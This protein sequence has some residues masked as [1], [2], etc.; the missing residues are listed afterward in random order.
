MTSLA[1]RAGQ[2]RKPVHRSTGDWPRP[3]RQAREENPA[4]PWEPQW[5]AV[6]DRAAA[7]GRG[8]LVSELPSMG[9]AIAGYGGSPAAERALEALFDVGRWWP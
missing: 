8:A 7:R 9:A 6:M 2:S 5:R 1:K 4:P 3:H